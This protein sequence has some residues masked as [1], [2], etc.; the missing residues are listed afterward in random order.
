MCGGGPLCGNAVNSVNGECLAGDLERVQVAEQPD[1]SSFASREG[2][3]VSVHTLKFRT[4]SRTIFDLEALLNTSEYLE[5]G[6]RRARVSRGKHDYGSPSRS[7][8]GE[9]W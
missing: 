8:S 1:G 3:F 2:H 5:P 6:S 7:A 9:V 4:R